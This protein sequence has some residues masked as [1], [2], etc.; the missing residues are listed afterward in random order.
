[1]YFIWELLFSAGGKYRLVCAGRSVCASAGTPGDE[2]AGQYLTRQMKLTLI[3]AELLKSPL[4]SGY[5]HFHSVGWISPLA[6]GAMLLFHHLLLRFVNR[7]AA[8]EARGLR[9]DLVPVSR[10]GWDLCCWGTPGCPMALGAAGHAPGCLSALK[11][12]ALSPT[13]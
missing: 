7:R 9:E 6:L 12:T 3:A 4:L 2:V 10:A 11:N 1:M 8:C 5:S 13:P